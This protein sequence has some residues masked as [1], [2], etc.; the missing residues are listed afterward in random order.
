MELTFSVLHALFQRGNVS[1]QLMGPG[2]VLARHRLFCA[3]EAFRGMRRAPGRIPRASPIGSPLRLQ[4]D[5]VAP[6]IPDVLAEDPIGRLKMLQRA[7][8]LTDEQ[9]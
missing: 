2:D 1:K 9:V 5:V 8:R 6:P 3:L 7:V 4:T